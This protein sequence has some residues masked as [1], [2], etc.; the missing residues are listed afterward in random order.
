MVA[1]NHFVTDTEAEVQVVKDY[2]ET[3]GSEAIL[4]Q[5]WEF[6][7]KGALDLAK[8]VAEIADSGVSQFAPLYRDDMPL[9]EKIE[10]IAK[11]IYR[12]DVM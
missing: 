12:A 5:H 3:Q 7:S 1:I 9:M 4:S 11:R 6:G 2:V 10:T 8:R